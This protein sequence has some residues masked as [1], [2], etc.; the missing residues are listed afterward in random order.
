[1]KSLLFLVIGVSLLNICA[2][3]GPPFRTDDSRLLPYL[4]DE[5]YFFST[6][7]F[8]HAGA[9]GIGPSIE[10]NYEFLRKGFVHLVVPLAFS[11]PRILIRA[12]DRGISN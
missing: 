1:M 11:D 12:L 3:A 10:F 7:T 8:D 9:N 6:G 2:F 5:I 4:G